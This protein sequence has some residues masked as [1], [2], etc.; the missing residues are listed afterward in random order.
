MTSSVYP[1]SYWD[2]YCHTLEAHH[3]GNGTLRIEF[4][5]TIERGSMNYTLNCSCNV[6]SVKWNAITSVLFVQ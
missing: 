5:C 6:C 2:D 4:V 1:H 3:H